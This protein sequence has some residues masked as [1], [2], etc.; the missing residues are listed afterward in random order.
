MSELWLYSI[1]RPP[2]TTH[3]STLLSHLFLFFS[4]IFSHP[5]YLSLLIFFSPFLLK[6][7]SFLSPLLITTSLLLLAF[8]LC[9]CHAVAERLNSSKMEDGDEEIRNIEELEAYKIFFDTSTFHESEENCSQAD[10]DL[11]EKTVQVAWEETTQ[12]IKG[13][14]RSEDGVK[15]LINHDVEGQKVEEN[16]AKGDGTKR[17]DNGRER[18]PKVRVE[19]SQRHDSN[20]NSITDNGGEYT[21][22]LWES[23][24]SRS[25][26]TSLGSYGSM[27]REKEWKRTLACKLF[28]ERHNVDGVEGMDSLWERYEMD[29]SNIARRRSHTK[30]KNKNKKKGVENY[31]D[32]DEEEDM[33]GQLCCLQALKFS[34]GKMNLGMGRPNLV[35]ISKAIKGIGWLQHVTRHRKKGYSSIS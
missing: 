3:F 2:K 5:L 20:A 21:S 11:Q 12:P 30:S 26:D 33:A 31:G 9:S 15:S 13:E 19:C 18:N 24:S 23:P 34:A 22:K 6:L 4:F 32:G 28:E 14:K 7:L 29:S 10:D 8:V 16:K 1:P 17:T 25:L 35:K 27:R